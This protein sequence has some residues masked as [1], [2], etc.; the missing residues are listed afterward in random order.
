MNFPLLSIP[1][2][3]VLP[4]SRLNSQ[5]L[6]RNLTLDSNKIANLT[7]L[8]FLGLRSLRR[9]SMRENLI[10]ELRP[11]VFAH[12]EKVRLIWCRGTAAARN[13]VSLSVCLPA[14]RSV[15]LAGVAQYGSF[16]SCGKLQMLPSLLFSL[17]FVK[18]CGARQPLLA[19]A[20]QTSRRGGFSSSVLLAAIRT[21]F[22][23]S[24]EK[25]INSAK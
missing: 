2:I 8:T 22:I 21:Q 3:S 17:P 9:L 4:D 5:K 23:S 11:N 15:G 1:R 25:A 6:L 24:L 20:C 10:R 7:N 13:L 14:C 12:L 16:V 19:K 18:S